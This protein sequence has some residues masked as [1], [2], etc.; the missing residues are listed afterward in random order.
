MNDPVADTVHELARRARVAA[1]VL[2][3]TDRTAKDAALQAMADALLSDAP[4]I[5]AANAADVQ[6]ARDG[7]THEHL[8]DRLQ[9]DS[10]RMS[11]MAEGTREIAGLP[12]PVGEVVRGSTLPN[13]LQLRQLRVPFGVVGIIYE[14]RPNV[15]ADAA[16]L[17]LKSGNAVLL[18]GS[19]SA[20]R[21]NASIVQSLRSAVESTGLPADSVQAVDAAD[22]ASAAHLM[23]ARGLVDLV[24]PRGGAGLIR[25][26]VEEST[27]PVIETGVGN[28]HVYVDAAADL[29]MALAIVLNSKTHRTSVCNSAESLLVHEAVAK[30]FLPVLVD[31]LQSAGVTIHGDAAFQD[32]SEHVLSATEEDFATEYLSWD[33]SAAVVSSLDDAVEHIR[34]YSSGHTEAI[35]T[36]SLSAARQFARQVDAAAVMVNASTRFTDGAQ[37]GF[38]AEIGISTQKL[39]ARGPM[40]LPELTTTTYVMSG[41]GHVR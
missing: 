36:G 6:A 33:I 8:V 1:R 2:A 19:G 15:T 17:C 12:D 27:V 14:A 23:R 32:A 40:G 5:L 28:C 30:D 25:T 3:D 35:V 21:T 26:V 13:G 18:R 34:T 39:H 38:G 24:I 11:A 29:D 31:A 9:L 10:T 22:R 4:S 37:F 20:A 16:A 7:G 41:S